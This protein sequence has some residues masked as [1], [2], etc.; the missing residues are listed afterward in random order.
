MQPGQPKATIT[1]KGHHTKNKTK[2]LTEKK[3]EKKISG[4]ITTA[5][6]IAGVRNLAKM[7]PAATEKAANQAGTPVHGKKGVVD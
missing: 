1:K 3:Q 2:Y 5:G 6:T 7:V 4:E